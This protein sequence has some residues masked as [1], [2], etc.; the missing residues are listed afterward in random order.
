[1]CFNDIIQ[2]QPT[3]DLEYEYVEIDKTYMNQ[4]ANSTELENA[5]LN[6]FINNHVTFEEKVEENGEVKTYK[7]KNILA[8]IKVTSYYNSVNESQSN[9]SQAGRDLLNQNDLVGF[10][11]ACGTYYIRSLG[12]YASFMALFKYRIKGDDQDSQQ[13]EIFENNLRN[14]MFRFYKPTRQDRDFEQ[15]VEERALRINLQAIGLGK[16]KFVDLLPTDLS[17]FKE[18]IEGAIKLMQ[19]PNSG[20]ITSMEIVPWFENV[21]FQNSLN[22]DDEEELL[23]FRQRK[24]LEQNSGVISEIERIDRVQMNQYYKGLN[25]L[26]VL[27]EDYPI[28]DGEFQYN[29]KQTWFYNHANK[30]NKELY[31]NLE[32][33]LQHINSESVEQLYQDNQEFLHGKDDK[34]GA[35]TCVDKI[36]KKGITEVNYREIDECRN[37]M[38]TQ[39]RQVPFI[40]HY[41]LPEK[42]PNFF[43]PINLPRPI[44]RPVPNPRPNLPDV[45]RN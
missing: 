6:S 17:D 29:P 12:R 39:I 43:I 24:N 7:V 38:N 34:G 13:N 28:G 33:L 30:T 36:Y 23:R 45:G 25:C 21:Q 18:T 35:L 4:T 16:G 10:F 15:E 22:L 3:Y 19:D 5:Y 42:V 31:K 1:M 9:I 14:R 27:K 41:C 8:H 37:I 32:T 40:N 2:T 44:P 11:D 26:R 20:V